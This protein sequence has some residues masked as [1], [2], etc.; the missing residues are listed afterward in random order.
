MDY[1]RTFQKIEEIFINL[2]FDVVII[3]ETK[4]MKYKE[5]YCKITFLKDW[6]AFVIESADSV[7]DAENGILEDG[8]LYYTDV[9]ED[10]LLNKLRDDLKKDYINL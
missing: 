2:G 10:E 8:D 4:F 9:S 3:N 6:S 5:C 7:L 1:S